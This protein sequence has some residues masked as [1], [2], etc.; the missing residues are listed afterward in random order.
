[1]EE[2]W[3]TV[4][5]PGAAELR[6]VRFPLAFDEDG[7]LQPGSEAMWLLYSAE[8]GALRADVPLWI[9]VHGRMPLG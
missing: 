2:G 8:A 5:S 3:Q 1:V 9:V 4:A 7:K 6:T